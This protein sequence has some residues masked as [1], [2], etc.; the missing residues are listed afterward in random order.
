MAK[1]HFPATYI[2]KPWLR[3][4][5]RLKL[6]KIEKKCQKLKKK[7]QVIFIEKNAKIRG[8]EILKKLHFN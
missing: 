6:V 1:K 7:L 2:I 5:V 8:F 4:S 3:F